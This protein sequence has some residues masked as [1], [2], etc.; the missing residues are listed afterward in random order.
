MSTFKIII[1]LFLFT[2]LTTTS[3]VKSSENSAT[4]DL[5]SSSIES[6]I[7]RPTTDIIENPET[8]TNTAKD[9]LKQSFFEIE[10]EILSDCEGIQ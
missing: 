3:K 2:A 6:T 8:I 5:G 10:N 4:I 7:R 9:V 1:I